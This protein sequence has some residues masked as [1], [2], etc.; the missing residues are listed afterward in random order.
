LLIQLEAENREQ[1]LGVQMI[2]AG[3]KSAAADAW[4]RKKMIAFT[5]AAIV[6][7]ARQ[8]SFRFKLATGYFSRLQAP[9][10]IFHPQE[11][12]SKRVRHLIE[13]RKATTALY[14]LDSSYF[15]VRSYNFIPGENDAC[16]RCV[17]GHFENAQ[18]MKCRPF[19]IS[20]PEYFSFPPYLRE[21]V[22]SGK[23]RVFSQSRVQA[24]LA[25]KH[26]GGSTDGRLVGMW[27]VDLEEMNQEWPEPPKDKGFDV[28][29]HG[30]FQPAKGFDWTLQIA[31][32]LPELTFLFPGPRP[33]SAHLPIS[34]N[35]EFI[36]MTWESGLRDEVRR[37]RITLVPSLW[38]A[39]IEGALVKS[40]IEA[41]AVGVADVPTSFSSEFPD[42]IVVRLPN[43]PVEAA[44]ALKNALESSWKPDP[45]ALRVWRAEWNKNRPV[46]RRILE[47]LN[48]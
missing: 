27:T 22:R 35:C 2:Y 24:N 16:L 31:A 47:N 21:K 18:K 32:L 5:L 13:T 14:L 7:F 38:S 10:L 8:F 9:L 26:F 3:N 33:E 12:G 44:A 30:T 41:P 28:V 25:L 4:R 34:K 11:I 20:N 48:A 15:C 45:Q 23:L 6:H 37:S 17:G 19:P 43:D 1:N 42:S 39:P 46:T 40:V 29:F 36:P